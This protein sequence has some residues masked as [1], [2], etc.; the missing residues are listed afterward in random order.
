MEVNRRIWQVDWLRNNEIA[1]NGK[2][3]GRCNRVL[4]TNMMMRFW[5]VF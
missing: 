1:V 4:I 3:D 5:H 2:E